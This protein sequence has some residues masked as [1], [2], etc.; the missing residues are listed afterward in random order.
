MRTIDDYVYCIYIYI[1]IGTIIGKMMI[2]LW[3]MYIYIYQL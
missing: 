1:Y 2:F 3:G